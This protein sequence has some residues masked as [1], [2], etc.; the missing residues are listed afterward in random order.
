MRVG[1]RGFLGRAGV[2]LAVTGGLRRA[3]A[4]PVS[5]PGDPIQ[6]TMALRKAEFRR[7]VEAIPKELDDWNAKASAVLDLNAHFS[8]LQAIQTLMNIFIDRQRELIDGLRAD[9]D[10]T[11]FLD[12][13]SDV[14]GQILRS[15][16]VWDF[17]RSKLQLRFD[18]LH[19][20]SL[21]VADTIAWDCYRPTLERAA[22]LD[23]L[24]RDELREPPLCYYTTEFSPA[25]W[26]R[27]SYPAELRAPKRGAYRTPIP[28]IEVPW[29]H[30][31]NLWSF[32]TLAH[33]VGHDLEED[34]KLRDPLAAALEAAGADIPADRLLVWKD[35][36]GEIFADL[37]GLQLVGPALTETLMGLLMLPKAEVTN[38]DKNDPHPTH[39]VRILMNTA[40]IR[41]LITGDGADAE[42]QRGVLSQHAD[43]IE[44]AWKGIYGDP[45]DLRRFLPDFPHVFRALMDTKQP[46]LKNR[47]L[48]DVIPYT[49]DDDARIRGASG[50]LRTGQE[51]PNQLR[52]RH[53][54]AAACQAV[55]AA[56][57]EAGDLT[58]TFN[59]INLRTARLVR[60]NGPPGLRASNNSIAHKR[61]ISQ[62]ADPR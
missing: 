41:T 6:S 18:P 4:T 56:A 34:L 19:K 21:W 14:V 24:A 39:Y 61:F 42:R 22:D 51:R 15:Q 49:A 31:Q 27:G 5:P 62:F 13:V 46:V 25:T 35:W 17:F 37:V 16:F 58:D 11:E 45:P 57:A 26:V 32:V 7:R 44:S 52:P 20:D 1:R 43:Q 3:A 9:G 47:T 30:A 23:I 48:R 54:A 28:V 8:Q 40:Y 10:P 50:Y 53:V 55:T 12:R 36:R 2:G 29:D 59:Q 38:Y 60:D 33:E